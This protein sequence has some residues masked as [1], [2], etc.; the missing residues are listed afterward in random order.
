MASDRAMAPEPVPRSTATRPA[1]APAPARVA[2]GP[3]QPAELGQGHLHHL[4]GLGAGDEH[5]PIDLELE[6]AERPVAEH[7][8]EGLPCRP[9]VGQ[10]ATGSTGAP[11]IHAPRRASAD[12]LELT[13]TPRESGRWLAPARP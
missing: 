2:L 3:A 1:P 5:P 11:T 6:V 12:G 4:L 13:D 10:T 9:P 8:L 7:V